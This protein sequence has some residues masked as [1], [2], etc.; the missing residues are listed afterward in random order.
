MTDTTP[1]PAA[2]ELAERLT[3]AREL[4]L[5][6]GS[7]LLERLGQAG[8][9]AAKA[10]TEFVTDADH[11]AEEL[12]LAGLSR[13]FPQDSVLA[14]ESG[15][16]VVGA[17]DAERTWYVDPLDG[18]T[19]FA[20]GYPF[21]AVSIACGDADGVLVGAVCAPCLD[22][23][24]TASRGGGATLERPAHHR[25]QA[26]GRRRQLPLASA[27][28]ATG[29]PYVRDA[30]VDLNTRLVRDFLVAPCHGVR[31]GG[32]AAIDLC[33]TA[34]GKLDGYWEWRLR[35]WDTAAG[36]LVAREAGCVVTDAGGVAVPVPADSVVAAA[37]GL[38]AEMLAVIAAAAG[39][40]T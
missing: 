36:A 4:A 13:R 22:E 34:A 10:G 31:R 21:F 6:A 32:S 2:A 24:Y 37:P 25:R 26:L 29:F 39:G 19:N 30:T 1:G 11:E 23:L 17:G 40:T 27:L 7:L 35:P 3:V 28:L 15:A 16:S 8:V 38:H 20:H 9:Q 5:A 18:T 14:E 12:V 33:H